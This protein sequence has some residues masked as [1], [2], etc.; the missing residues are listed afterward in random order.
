MSQ[1]KRL[2]RE[3]I[4]AVKKDCIEDECDEFDPDSVEYEEYCDDCKKR[5]MGESRRNKK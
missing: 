5:V 3:E 1:L 2:I 4:K